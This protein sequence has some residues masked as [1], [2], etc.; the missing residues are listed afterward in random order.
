MDLLVP[1]KKKLSEVNSIKKKSKL[2]AIKGTEDVIHIP[3]EILKQMST[4]AALS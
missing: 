4:D 2:E 3:E 1:L